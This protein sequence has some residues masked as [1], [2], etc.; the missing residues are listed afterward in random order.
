MCW[1][2]S[3]KC[4]KGM[5]WRVIA[6]RL[7]GKRA[8]HLYR[9][10]RSLSES[11]QVIGSE[12]WMIWRYGLYEDLG[13]RIPGRGGSQSTSAVCLWRRKGDSVTKNGE[14]SK[15]HSYLKVILRSLCFIEI[16]LCYDLHFK[17][18]TPSALWPMAWVQGGGKLL[19]SLGESWW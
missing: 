5:W 8:A 9:W 19:G 1:G 12:T 6:G 3:E 7:E 17:K 2:I 10:L 14:R 18:V 15:P 13:K 11:M 16:A 4:N